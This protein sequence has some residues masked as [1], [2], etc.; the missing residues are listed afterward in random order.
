MNWLGVAAAVL[1]EEWWLHRR[2]QPLLSHS[3]WDSLDHPNQRS[4]TIFSTSTLL[5]HL[6]LRMRWPHA[7]TFGAG[8]AFADLSIRHVA[9]RP[10]RRKAQR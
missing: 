3:Y 9:R 7:L 8:A 6:P 1:L 4:L 2:Q 10:L 5:A